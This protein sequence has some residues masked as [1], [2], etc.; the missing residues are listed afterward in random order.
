M[1][2]ARD[3]NQQLIIFN[4]HKHSRRKSVGRDDEE[5]SMRDVE[6][7]KRGQR[8]LVRGVPSLKCR[9]FVK[10]V[11]LVERRPSVVVAAT[12]QRYILRG[13]VVLRLGSR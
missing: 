3:L 11:R 6:S 12:C 7:K 2:L 4:T 13:K 5:K 9:F 10:R 1:S 8:A